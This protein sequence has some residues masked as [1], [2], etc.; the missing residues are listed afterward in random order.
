MGMAVYQSTCWTK[1]KV[2]P[3]SNT[4]ILFPSTMF[5]S[6]APSE[7]NIERYVVAFNYFAFGNFGHGN[8]LQ[9]SLKNNLK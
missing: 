1:N 4:L 9:L 6:V 8:N 2:R 3:K 7:S 5:H